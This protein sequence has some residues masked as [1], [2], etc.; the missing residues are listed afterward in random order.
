MTITSRFPHRSG[1]NSKT[2]L[3]KLLKPYKGVIGKIREIYISENKEGVNIFLELIQPIFYHHAMSICYALVNEM[4]T[5][6]IKIYF[7]DNIYKQMLRKLQ[8]LFL[9]AIFD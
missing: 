1:H 4:Y 6:I 9:R 2:I 8:I 3:S 7:S 5:R